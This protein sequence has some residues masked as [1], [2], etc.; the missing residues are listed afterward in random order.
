MIK[1]VNICS[2]H[3]DFKK[4]NKNKKKITDLHDEQNDIFIAYISKIKQNYFCIHKYYMYI[5]GYCFSD[6]A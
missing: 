2:N 3:K 4:K 6:I 5:Y 1:I